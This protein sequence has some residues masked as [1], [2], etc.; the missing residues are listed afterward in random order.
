MW[1]GEARRGQARLGAAWHGIWRGMARRGA[2]GLRKAWNVARH[3]RAR[4]GTSTAWNKG[5]HI[6]KNNKPTQPMEQTHS[7]AL[8]N[9]AGALYAAYL[10]AAKEHHQKMRITSWPDFVCDPLN[11]VSVGCWI[12]V[13][14][15]A[16]KMENDA[17]D[18]L[19]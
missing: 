9:Y 12:A 1:R 16:V 8:M 7:N 19:L 14:K 2:A 5:G 3:G 18:N 15:V 6:R 10:T 4:H 17:R 13:A 11:K